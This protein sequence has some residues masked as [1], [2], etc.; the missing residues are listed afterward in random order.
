MDF[1]GVLGVGWWNVS[2]SGE[3]KGVGIEGGNMGRNSW[4]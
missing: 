3:G 1:T 4:N 2:I